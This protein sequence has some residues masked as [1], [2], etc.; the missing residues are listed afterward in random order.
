LGRAGPG[1]FALGWEWVAHQAVQSRLGHFQAKRLAQP[2]LKR[3]RAGK[4]TRGRQA[5][6][7]PLAHGRREGLV[8]GRGSRLFGGQSSLQP[9][10]TRAAEP[11]GH[12]IPVQSQM[13]RGLAPRGHL[14]RL[15]QDEAGQPGLALGVALAMQPCWQGLEVCEHGR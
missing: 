6:L 4:P 13:R 9:P 8:P 7:E 2:L 3:H 11:G 1:A 5:R 14:S 15:E 10:G 12:G